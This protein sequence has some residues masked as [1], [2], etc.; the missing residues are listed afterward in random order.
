M[1]PICTAGQTDLFLHILKAMSTR[2]EFLATF[3]TAHI[4]LA[5]VEVVVPIKYQL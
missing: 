2:I 4:V 5:L 3:T 1:P